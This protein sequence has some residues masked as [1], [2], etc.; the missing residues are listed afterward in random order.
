MVFQIEAFVTMY[1]LATVTATSHVAMH[2][3]IIHGLF[4][5]VIA[6]LSYST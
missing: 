1:G 4:S 3:V 5:S 2:L 6:L